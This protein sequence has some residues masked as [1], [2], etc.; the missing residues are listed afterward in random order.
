MKHRSEIHDKR[1]RLR[2]LWLT[3]PV[4]NAAVRWTRSRRPRSPAVTCANMNAGSAAEK[5]LWIAELRCG[6]YSLTPI[7]PIQ[8]NE[9]IAKPGAQTQQSGQEL[10]L[11]PRPTILLKSCLVRAGWECARNPAQ[12]EHVFGPV[13]VQDSL[14]RAPWPNDG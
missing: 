12:S 8:K 4:R 9:A 3:G 2:L 7:I 14:V 1:G 6:R 11:L 5:R 13:P 10:R